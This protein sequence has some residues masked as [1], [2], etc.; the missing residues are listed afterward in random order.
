[1]LG[2]M[3][4]PV[5]RPATE[6][7]LRSLSGGWGR[8]PGLYWLNV[9]VGFTGGVLAIGPLGWLFNQL[10]LERGTAAVLSL[11]LGQVAGMGWV[12]WDHRRT[13]RR[14]QAAGERHREA[15]E[16][17]VVRDWTL[18]VERCWEVAIDHDDSPG[19]IL[20]QADGSAV[21]IQ[22]QVWFDCL[23]EDGDDPP[24]RVRV[25]YAP[26]TGRL[27]NLEG[28]GEPVAPLHH[29]ATELQ[30]ELEV[31]ELGPAEVVRLTSARAN[32]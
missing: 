25:V 15:Y 28:E 8:G 32:P 19:F 9:L 4:A 17:G 14:A 29:E 22:G 16:A 24:R 21:Y 10:G 2:Q 12:W 3:P 6:D 1:M 13:T 23:P 27:V 30:G 7:E 11:V 26:S 31:A 20:Q 5:E 18:E